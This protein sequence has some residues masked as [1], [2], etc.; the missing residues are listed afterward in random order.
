M[1]RRAS[2]TRVDRRTWRE[3]LDSTLRA[4]RDF[5]ERVYAM[6]GEDDDAPGTARA[7]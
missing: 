7:V 2:D 6:R 4:H 3:L 1:W 5:L